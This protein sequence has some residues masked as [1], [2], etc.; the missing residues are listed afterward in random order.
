[1]ELGKEGLKPFR[2]KVIN[3][4]DLTSDCWPV[5][6]WGL[7]YCSGFGDPEKKCDYLATKECGGYRIRKMILS[8]EYPL[9]GLAD[10]S[11]K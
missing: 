8:G 5:Q 4:T 11:S 9:N 2:S 3:Q 1:M 7:P 10:I 6:V